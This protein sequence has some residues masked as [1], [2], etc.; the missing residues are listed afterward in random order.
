MQTFLPYR[1]F[2]KSARVLDRL[3]LGKQRIEVLQILRAIHGLS[4]GWTNHP[5]AKLWQPHANALAS[6]G[7]AIC[8][9]WISRGYKDTTRPKI[10]A[11]LTS[12]AKLPTFPASYHRAHRSL[13]LRKNPAHYRPHW[14]TLSDAIPFIWPN[15]LVSKS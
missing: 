12:P 15:G 4:K 1:D 10:A 14:P 5:C 2:A 9:E 3:R 8:D 7:L 13:L 11:F 6:Y